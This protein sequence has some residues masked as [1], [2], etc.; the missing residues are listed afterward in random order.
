M[1][2]EPNV[3]S[4]WGS[5]LESESVSRCR[6]QS[7]IAHVRYKVEPLLSDTC[8]QGT[9]PFRGHKIWSRKNTHT[10]LICIFYLH[11]RDRLFIEKGHFFFVPEPRFNLHLGDTFNSTQNVTDNKEGCLIIKVYTNHDND[12]FHNMANQDTILQRNGY[13]FF[14]YII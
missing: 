11:W 9:P 2:R 8:I 7:Q 12:S 4:S 14:V 1:R 6:N 3:A 5:C 10:I 13:V